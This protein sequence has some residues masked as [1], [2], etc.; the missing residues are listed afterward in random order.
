MNRI[1][2]VKIG[3]TVY[4][5]ILDN[6]LNVFVVPRRISA[7]AMRFLAANRRCDRRFALKAFGI[8]R[9]PASRIF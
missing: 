7:K 2:Y 8:E 1:E 3:E 9:R 6:G 4:H 5:E